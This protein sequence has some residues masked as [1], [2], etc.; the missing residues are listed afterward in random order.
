M[1]FHLTSFQCL[2]KYFL[3]TEKESG[4]KAPCPTGHRQSA[5]TAA[6]GLRLAK[7]SAATATPGE[8]AK[9]LLQWLVE[10]YPLC[11]SPLPNTILQ[12]IMP[13]GCRL[14]ATALRSLAAS[15]WLPWAGSLP[16]PPKA[17]R[18]GEGHSSPFTCC[19]GF[20]PVPVRVCRDKSMQ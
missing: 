7:P 4:G 11:I 20:N 1:A 18:G 12:I 14:S 6:R 17:P 13:P 2:F 5:V 15:P 10:H 19:E 8:K 3:V 16:D 9:T